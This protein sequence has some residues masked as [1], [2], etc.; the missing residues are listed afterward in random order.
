MC[1]SIRRQSPSRRRWSTAYDELLCG[2]GG[3][4]VT[5]AI[6][7]YD[8][9]MKRSKNYVNVYNKQT[10]FMAPRKADGTWGENR[11]AGFT[12]GSPWT[13]DMAHS[14]TSGRVSK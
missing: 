10:G 3:Q 13:Y 5:G 8:L 4:E 7:V 12:E 11:R 14:M 2:T 6:A 1:L 9:L